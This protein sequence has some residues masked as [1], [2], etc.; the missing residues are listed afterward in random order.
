MYDLGANRVR[1]NDLWALRVDVERLALSLYGSK[2]FHD[3]R[4]ERQL[5]MVCVRAGTLNRTM[6]LRSQERSE[7]WA[8][9]PDTSGWLARRRMTDVEPREPA[10]RWFKL[11]RYHH[12]QHLYEADVFFDSGYYFTSVRL[13][14]SGAFGSLV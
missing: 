10:N 7:V 1:G 8:G 3:L 13:R 12:D 14:W 9:V 11:L 5:C 4:G 6:Q 2:A